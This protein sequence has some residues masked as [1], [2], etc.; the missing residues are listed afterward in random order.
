MRRCTRNVN[1]EELREGRELG[2]PFAIP[3]EEGDY[4]ELEGTYDRERLNKLGQIEDLE[5]ALGID[6]LTLF[7]AL[8]DGVWC[9]FEDARCIGSPSLR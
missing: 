2:I 8:M 5:E 1:E 4:C 6:L 7:K 9:K 3:Y